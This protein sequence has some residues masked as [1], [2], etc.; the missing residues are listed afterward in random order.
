MSL[1][2]PLVLL[3]LLLLPLYVTAR[4]KLMKRS[5]VP[6]PPLQ[7]RRGPASRRLAAGWRLPL[8]AAFLAA[9]VLGVAGPHRS[10][11]VELLGG[12][13]IDVA[14]VLD[15]SLSMKADDFP[16][17]RLEALRVIARRFVEESGPNRFALLIFAGDVF[18]QSPMTTD[19][20]AVLELI[21]GMS[22][23]SISHGT[24]EIGGS[25]GTAIGDA[26][27]AAAERLQAVRVEGRDQAL[28]LLT[29]GD[30]TQGVDPELAARW[31]AEQDTSVSIIGIGRE[32][33]VAVTIE[34]NDKPYM[35]TLD[36]EELAAIAAA[37]GGRFYRAT[38]AGALAEVFSEL[39]RLESA[40]LEARRVEIHRPWTSG[41]A[42]A[43]LPLYAVYLFLAGFVARRPLR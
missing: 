16:P 40:P 5:A 20:R 29:D 17:N 31:V 3:L 15:V 7:Y 43:A 18:V 26:L 13:G 36:T 10:S 11:S 30:N 33:P 2:R 39:A 25:G 14:L 9:L 21:D 22:F 32:E 38:D 23:Q 6:H 42:L 4:R 8:E 27:L 34:G 1:E 37:T 24:E 41:V 19:R 35:A 28:I 12:D